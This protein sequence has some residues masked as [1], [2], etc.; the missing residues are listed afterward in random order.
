MTR[1]SIV[2]SAIVS[3]ETDPEKYRERGVKNTK[4]M[5][6]LEEDEKK[7]QEEVTNECRGEF[8]DSFQGRGKVAIFAQLDWR[9][10]RGT[11]SSMG[12][13]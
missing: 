1:N 2:L 5:K 13:W 10:D 7:L 8:M 4:K 3:G 6:V 12:R 9:G 11:V